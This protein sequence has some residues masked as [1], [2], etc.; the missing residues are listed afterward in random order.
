MFFLRKLWKPVFFGLFVFTV[1]LTQTSASALKFSSPKPISVL[2]E[3]VS[4]ES[5]LSTKELESR[6]RLRLRRNGISLVPSSAINKYECSCFL[7]V[8]LNVIELNNASGGYLD[9]FAFDLEVRF[10]RGDLVASG[11]GLVPGTVWQKSWVGYSSSS[12]R[13]RKDV[14]ETLESMLDLFSI[15][16]IEAN[17]L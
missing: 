12:S 8:N 2:V 10:T 7:Y 13:F 16:F 15:E 11:V 3:S 4:D 14:P 1:A 9:Q 17:D 6:T 5:P